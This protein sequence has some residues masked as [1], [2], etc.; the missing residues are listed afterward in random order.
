MMPNAYRTP[1]PVAPDREPRPSYEVA[2]A[3]ALTWA[4][5][6]LRVAFVL[7]RS[8]APSRETDFAWLFVVVAPIVVW[9]E[10]AAQRG[11]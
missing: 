6:L 9:K 10:I 3:V 11:R 2:V 1:A 7:L 5:A 4:L 8:E